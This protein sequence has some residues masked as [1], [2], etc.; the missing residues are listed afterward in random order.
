VTLH[1]NIVH[2]RWGQAEFADFWP[3]LCGLSP[4]SRPLTTL[5]P[6]NVSCH[7]C[8]RKRLEADAATDKEQRKTMPAR[9]KPDAFA[10]RLAT[11]A[12]EDAIAARAA[13][14]IGMNSQSP[15][16]A[17]LGDEIRALMEVR[18]S[19]NAQ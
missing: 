6:E 18:E 12:L 16:F 15:T 8:I 9:K 4:V 2:E 11:A 13:K 10:R 7:V 3:T 19:I 14:R 1:E 5:D 17:L